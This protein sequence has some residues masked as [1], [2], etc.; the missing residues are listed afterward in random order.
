[1]T[2]PREICKNEGRGKRE[3]RKKEQVD[4]GEKIIRSQLLDL[5]SVMKRSTQT[6]MFWNK[7]KEFLWISKNCGKKILYISE[8][9]VWVYD[10]FIIELNPNDRGS[11][12]I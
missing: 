7:I 11:M 1:M 4:G 12:S 10:L 8:N 6:S 3:K 9:P 5:I 2:L